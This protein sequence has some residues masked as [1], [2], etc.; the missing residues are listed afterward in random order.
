MGRTKLIK[1]SVFHIISLGILTRI[2]NILNG[3][4]LTYYIVANYNMDIYILGVSSTVLL[5]SIVVEGLILALI[6]VYQE[7]EMQQGIEG[8]FKFTNNIINLLILISLGFMIIGYGL[9]PVIVKSL[10]ANFGE[11][12]IKQGIRLFRIGIPAIV[13]HFIRAISAGYL[14]GDHRFLAGAKSGVANISIYILYLLIFKDRFGLEGLAVAGLLAVA[15]QAYVLTKP[16]F[17]DGYRYKFNINLERKNYE[18]L[19]SFLVPIMIF[20]IIT[21]LDR[22][23]GNEVVLRFMKGDVLALRYAREIIDFVYGLIIFAIVT[24]LFPILAE[25]YNH[26]NMVELKKNIN[27]GINILLMVAIPISFVFLVLGNPIVSI[28]YGKGK[29]GGEEIIFVAEI[30]KFYA[31]GLTGMSLSLSIVR[32]YYAIH[33]TKT[34]IFLGL[35]SLFLNLVL[36]MV[37]VK[38]MREIGVPL[39]ISITSTIIA[40]LGIYGLNRKANIILPK[41]FRFLVGGIAAI[42]LYGCALL[43]VFF[44]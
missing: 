18:R 28:I 21:Q 10:G 39:I 34:P 31:L 11:E 1:K 7:I 23:I 2:L 17:K 12:E 4:L 42:I 43:F 15:I 32:I 35:L 33:D 20:I 25:N 26:G 6:P 38:H 8:R 3:F 9:A 40:V 19:V 41:T 29:L 27:F 37:L 30:L 16:L 14:Q 24:V 13:F 5:T 36:N 22:K 44:Y